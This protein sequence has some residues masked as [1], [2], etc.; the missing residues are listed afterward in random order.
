MSRTGHFDPKGL[1]TLAGS[2]VEMKTFPKPPD[3]AKFYT[4]KFLPKA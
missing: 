1:A 3:M 2:Y 4:E